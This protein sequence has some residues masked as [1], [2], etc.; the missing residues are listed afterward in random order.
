[1]ESVQTVSAEHHQT[2]LILLTGAHNIQD[3]LKGAANAL[4]EM[5]A[6]EMQMLN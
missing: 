1:M 4:S 5:K 2:M 3:G 6:E